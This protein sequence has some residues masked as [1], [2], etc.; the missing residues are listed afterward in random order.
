MPRN[1]FEKKPSE[2]SPATPEVAENVGNS[3]VINQEHRRI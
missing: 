1:E 3:P 2:V